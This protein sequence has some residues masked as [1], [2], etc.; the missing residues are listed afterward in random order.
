MDAAVEINHVGIEHTD[1]STRHLAAYRFGHVG[2]VNTIDRA[3]EINGAG[4]ERIAFAAGHPARKIRLTRNHLLRRRPIRPF[5][6]AR[7]NLG[8]CPSETIPSYAD[9]VADRS[10][11]AQNVV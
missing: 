11:I 10:S 5:S 7:N 2:A 4:T 9:P 8:P 3:A 1:A 6:F